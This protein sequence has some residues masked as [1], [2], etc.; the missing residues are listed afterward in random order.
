[1]GIL[2]ARLS[3]SSVHLQETRLEGGRHATEL[4]NPKDVP[5]RPSGFFSQSCHFE[6]VRIYVPKQTRGSLNLGEEVDT[7]WRERC[8]L[9]I[10]HPQAAWFAMRLGLRQ[11][12]CS[13]L[14]DSVWRALIDTAYKGTSEVGGCRLVCLKRNSR[15]GIFRTG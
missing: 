4:G 14:G 8:R 13:R 7:L 6:A 12:P 15:I 11:E 10:L 5:V 2:T 9:W 1:M 3:E